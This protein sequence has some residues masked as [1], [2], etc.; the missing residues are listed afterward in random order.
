MLRILSAATL[1]ASVVVVAGAS[2]S[3]ADGGWGGADCDQVPVAGCDVGAGDD[4]DHNGGGGDHQG[5]D[6]SGSGDGAGGPD[7]SNCRWDPAPDYSEPGQPD[8]GGGWF[9]LTCVPDFQDGPFWVSDGGPG[10]VSPRLLAE[11]ARKRLNLPRPVIA[12]SPGGDQLVALPMWLWL[13]NNMWTAVSATA[14]VPGVSVTATARPT[15]VTWSMGDGSTV[16][17]TGPGTLFPQGGD[18]RAASPTCGHTYT[19]ASE[20]YGVTATVRWTVTWAGAGTGGTF[21]NLTTFTTTGFRVAQSQA[22]VNR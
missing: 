8:T 12:A 22:I 10:P 17:C 19:R 18:P 6:G 13:G 2:P 3:S 4:G 11:T 20:R 15:S 21:P 1:L 7:Y 14:S 5:G 16:T 9:L